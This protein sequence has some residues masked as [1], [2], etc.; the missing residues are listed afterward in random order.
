MMAD[1]VLCGCGCGRPSGFA[2]RTD[3][4][5]GTVRGQ[6]LRFISGHRRRP[7]APQPTG[8]PRARKKGSYI[9]YHVRGR[10]VGEHTWKVEKA[11]GHTLPAGAVV[12]HA[13]GDTLNNAN[14]NLVAC[15]DTA[16]HQLLHQRQRALEACG[17]P[18]WRRCWV[19]KG[20]DDPENLT[21][22]ATTVVHRRCW[23]AKARE[24]REATTGEH[25]HAQ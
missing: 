21:I 24:Y 9:G 23:T 3:T 8:K 14:S 5:K 15:Q 10:Y 4:R 22:S 25:A 12:H 13:D 1:A 11:I 19:C 6:P 7:D 20:W 18:S 2:A 17:H 16:Y